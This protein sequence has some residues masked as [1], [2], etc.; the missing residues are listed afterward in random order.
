[1]NAAG[2]TGSRRIPCRQR[3][4][5]LVIALVLLTA[6]SLLAA[7]TLR[8]AISTESVSGAVR[9]SETALQA[10]EIALRYCERLA[11]ASATAKGGGAAVS[12]PPAAPLWKDLANWDGASPKRTVL[13]LDA[14]NASGAY[15]LYRR[16]PE[17]LAE[18]LVVASEDEVPGSPGTAMTS[19]TVFVITARGF[20]AD[21]AAPASPGRPIGTEVWLQSQIEQIHAAGAARPPTRAWR[22]LFMR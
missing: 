14:V 15:R 8:N 22:Q 16:A 6:I 13:P 5:V 1:M 7:S 4:I 19:A 21:V 17:C 10:A 11:L 12:A 9:T 20:G 2:M 18:P 3:G